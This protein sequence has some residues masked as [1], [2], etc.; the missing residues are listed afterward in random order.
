MYSDFCRGRIA[1]DP[2]GGEGLRGSADQLCAV[3][4]GSGARMRGLLHCV[5]PHPACER[6]KEND[7]CR[8]TCVVTR[9]TKPRNEE[10]YV[11]LV[12][13]LSVLRAQSLIKG[14]V[15]RIPLTS[16]VA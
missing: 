9:Q 12:R 16:P 7:T 11:G 2:R 1:L 8:A 3:A 15:L 4:S 5:G 14:E 10:V 13:A 6:T